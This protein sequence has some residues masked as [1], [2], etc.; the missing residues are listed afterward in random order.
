[1]AVQNNEVYAVN[2]GTYFS[3]P[4]PTGLEVIAKIDNSFTQYE[5]N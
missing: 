2:A 5:Y 4:G 3:K 1:L